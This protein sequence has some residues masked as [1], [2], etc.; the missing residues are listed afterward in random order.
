I[1]YA[2]RALSPTE[3][4]YSVGE[5]ETLACIW[6]CERW[7]MYL[8]GCAF[9]LQ[10]DHQALTAL[11]AT[12]GIGHRPL[13]LHRWS[14]R[15]Q[16][17][18]FAP[19]FT[20]RRENVVADLLSRSFPN[21]PGGPD[22]DTLEP[23]LIKMLYTALQATVSLQDL[24]RASEW[25]PVFS[26]LCTVI[27]LGWPS[28]VLAELG[29]FLCVK[30][31]LSCWNDFCVAQLVSKHLVLQ[32]AHTGHLGIVKVKQRCRD[33]VWWPGI[34]WDIEAPVRNCKACLLNRNT[35]E[36]PLPPLQPLDWP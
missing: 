19:Q 31:E 3:Q 11:L 13:R 25:D 18:N 14:V 36:P 10:T 21:L 28:K 5:R 32:M 8:Y 34:D 24:Q 27:H 1:D 17:Y 23:N 4:K 2:S 26:H 30:D 9:T 7:H 29:P 6:V 35:G 15:L 12:S 20:P 22:S 33:L 16:Q